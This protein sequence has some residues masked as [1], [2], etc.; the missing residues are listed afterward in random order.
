MVLLI[1][2]EACQ[3]IPMMGFQACQ[4]ISLNRFAACLERCLYSSWLVG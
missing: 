1:C 3:A 4:A 2:F